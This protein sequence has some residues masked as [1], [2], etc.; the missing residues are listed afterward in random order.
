MDKI[1][2]TDK[3]FMQ[4]AYKEARE[5]FNK[6]EV[7]VGA[8]IVSKG[9]IVA[10]AHNLTET[11]N[12]VTAHAEMLAITSAAETLGGKYLNNCTLYVTLEPCA[13][14]AGALS[15]AQISRIVYA[16]PDEKRGFSRLTPSPIHP[17][18]EV[19]SGIMAEECSMLVKEFFGKKR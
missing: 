19:V 12:D 1:D 18:T 3:Y 14:C 10:R 6:D 17:K 2:F 15:W 5:A 7:P 11:L 4:Q 13:M 16:A 8:V 9:Q